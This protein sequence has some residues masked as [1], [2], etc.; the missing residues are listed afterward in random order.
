[1]RHRHVLG[2]ANIRRA[3]EFGLRES[4]DTIDH[5]IDVRVGPDRSP[6]PP[7]FDR[8]TVSRLGHL[9]ADGGGRL[10]AT[11]RPCALGA[12][13]VLKPRDSDVDTVLAAERHV[14]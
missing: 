6:I 3:L 13:A 12:V 8:A 2:A 10:F 4:I 11:T 9:T 14:H 7:Y 5:V 1:M